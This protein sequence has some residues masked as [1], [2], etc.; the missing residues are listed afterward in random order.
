MVSSKTADKNNLVPWFT[1]NDNMFLSQGWVC[2]GLLLFQGGVRKP[3]GGR[4]KG[5]QVSGQCLHVSNLEVLHY[6]KMSTLMPANKPQMIAVKMWVQSWKKAVLHWTLFSWTGKEWTGPHRHIIVY[7][8]WNRRI[9]ALFGLRW[10]DSG[11]PLAIK[12]LQYKEK[13][14]TFSSIWNLWKERL[15]LRQNRKHTNRYVLKFIYL[16]GVSVLF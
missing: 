13:G 16:Y 15:A 6:V 5:V 11:L 8:P 14:M 10:G 3:R 9:M 1:D 4:R 2:W 12:N 7:I